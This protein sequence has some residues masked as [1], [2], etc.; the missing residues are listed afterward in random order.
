MHSRNGAFCPS[1]EG[2]IS[3]DKEQAMKALAAKI[4]KIEFEVRIFVSF[5]IVILVCTFCFSVFAH[6]PTNGVLIFKSA[7]LARETSLSIGFL[8]ATFLA[9][10]ASFF[11]MWSGSILTSRRMM[12]FRVQDD[13]LLIKGPYLLVRNPIYLAD[14]IAFF[15]FA[16]CLPPF[17]VLLPAL[18]YLHYTQLIK[19][20]EVSL[21]R[22]FGE[23]YRDYKAQIPQLI[24]NR[25]SLRRLSGAFK[26]LELNRDGIRH[27]AV[28]LGLI[29]GFVVASFTHNIFHAILVGLPA[30]LDWA[31]VHTKIGAKKDASVSV[32]E[33][34][35]EAETSLSQQRIFQD[36]LYAQCWE[37]P[38]IDRE[39]FHITPDDV[40]FSITS[41]GC[42][43]LA[44]LLD[45]PKKLIALDVNPHQNYLLRLKIAAFKELS[46]S[47]LLEFFGVRESGHRIALYGRLRPLL[48]KRSAQF[49]DGQSKKIEQG[50]IHCGR[51]ERYMRLLKKFVVAPLMGNG[52]VEEFFKAEDAE[53]RKEFFYK[54]L[55]N[56]RWWILTKIMLS[57]RLN[58]L[59]FDKAFFSHLEEKFSFGD[60]FSKK[61]ERAL[62]KLPMKENTFLSYIL[63]GKFY[64]EEHLPVYLK[65][66]N[67]DVIRSRVDRIEVVT[68]S[69][70]HYFSTLPGSSITR[71]NFTNIFEWMSEEAFEDLLK[72]AIRVARDKAIMTYRNLL[73]F[74]ECPESLR[75]HVRSL[76]ETARSLHE[77]DLSFIYNNYVVEEIQKGAFR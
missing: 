70:E 16:L 75:K 76:R 17:G 77:K 12:A 28:Y 11:R 42:N 65:R 43:A 25:K 3:G 2:R 53:Q 10:V 60:H 69:C 48:D 51:Y 74:R 14:L 20:E 61:A 13:T 46:Y 38:Q 22:Q 68:D 67:F 50:I 62:T 47:E 9:A 71:F 21:E 55:H 7:G 49:W 5:G 44:F 52:L 40:V 73:V 41:G 36:V 63:L 54:R 26:D 29:L 6:S 45:N 8:A 33:K 23:Q 1:G 4:Q 15:G 32:A 34:E 39:A 57:R 56:I 24:P 30:V 72:E 31:V 66:E 58:S 37:D 35:K 59:F 64:S 19:Y 27:N 18:L